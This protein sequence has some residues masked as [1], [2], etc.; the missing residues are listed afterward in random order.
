MNEVIGIYGRSVAFEEH[1]FYWHINDY[2]MV[3][4]VGVVSCF[5][6]YVQ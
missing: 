3:N 4:K 5:Y 2:S 1:N 6:I